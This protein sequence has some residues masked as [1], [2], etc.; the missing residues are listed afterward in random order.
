[1]EKGGRQPWHQTLVGSGRPE[2]RFFRKKNSGPVG[3]Y[4][5]V[6]KAIRYRTLTIDGGTTTAQFNH[7]NPIGPLVNTWYS[8][9]E[10]RNYLKIY[11]KTFARADWSQVLTTGFISV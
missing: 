8:L 6:L 9:V 2:L 4:S 10:K 3:V 7:L 5:A 11:D 1:M